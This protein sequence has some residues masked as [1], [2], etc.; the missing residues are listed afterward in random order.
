MH[1]M[2]TKSSDKYEI[3]RGGFFESQDV[4]QASK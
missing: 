1:T 3:E 4:I 2:G